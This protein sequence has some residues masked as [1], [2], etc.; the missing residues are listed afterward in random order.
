MHLDPVRTR[1][2]K[3]I[4][5]RD[6]DLKNA[7]LKIGKNAAYLHQFIFRGTPK[8]LPEDVRKPLAAFLGVDE[9]SLRH[10][11]VPPRKPRSK[12]ELDEAGDEAAAPRPQRIPEGFIGIAEIDV[13]ASAG[14][15]AFHEGLEETKVT[16]LFPEAMVRH[17]FR[18]PP[19]ELRMITVDGDSMEPLLSS[20]DRILIDTSQRVPVPPG[21]FVIWDGM[22][23]VA[24]RVEHIPNSDP[25]KVLVKSINPEYQAYERI[26]EEVNVVGRVVWAA[27]RL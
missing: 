23:L 24:K 2:L 5:D 21:I 17:E 1:V 6:A 3:L 25:P 8:A 26:A 20:G 14:P 12:P 4:E 22:G 19:K 27:R 16:W 18:A 10:R 11:R 13:R 7:S 9:D 15:G